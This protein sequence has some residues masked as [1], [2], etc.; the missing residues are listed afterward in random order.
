MPS[1]PRTADVSTSDHA[2]PLTVLQLVPTMKSGGV[3]RGAIEIA[4]ALIDR[5]DRALIASR[6]GRMVAQFR[7]IGGEFHE[8]DMATKSPIVMYRN[9]ARLRTL[10]RE[11]GVDIVHA[12]SRAPAWSGYYAARAE[13]VPFV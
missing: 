11:E 4:Q 1:D 12:R 7:R 8:L 10:I 3:E 6:G 9:V 5:G 2:R 13:G